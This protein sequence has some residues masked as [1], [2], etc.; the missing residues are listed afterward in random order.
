MGMSNNQDQG[1][2]DKVVDGL[3]QA[4]KLA[5]EIDFE[6]IRP[7]FETWQKKFEQGF[8]GDPKLLGIAA[9]VPTNC[10]KLAVLFTLA[11]SN[12][13]KEISPTA[14]EM[15]KRLALALYRETAN[16]LTDEVTTSLYQAN[17][18][19]TLDAIKK[20]PG[21]SRRDLLRKLHLPSRDFNAIVDTLLDE[22]SI[23]E[24]NTVRGGR[25][26]VCYWSTD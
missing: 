2:H 8:S 21:I 12:K 16:I 1:L 15:G 18:K 6:S 26:S 25:S 14:W 13:A 11:E 4:S 17:R 3:I 5:G 24:E 7:D 22:E 9:R 19:R 10:L 20:S 23:R